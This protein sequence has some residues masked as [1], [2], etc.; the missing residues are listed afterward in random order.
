MLPGLALKAMSGSGIG[1]KRAD[2]GLDHT[3][4]VTIV[5][6]RGKWYPNRVM[7]LSGVPPA[8]GREYYRGSDFLD[9]I[10]QGRCLRLQ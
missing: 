1:D 3:H 2:G 5:W 10:R 7:A 4:I 6:Y 8:P 9:E